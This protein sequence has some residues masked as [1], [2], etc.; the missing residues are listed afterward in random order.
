MRSLVRRLAPLLALILPLAGCA[1]FGAHEMTPRPAAPGEVSGQVMW[2]RLGDEPATAQQM[3]EASCA[4]HGLEAMTQ[5]PK[6][7]G[8]TAVMRYACK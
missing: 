7:D 1:W 6:A 8:A 4:R 5:S 2:D 3:A